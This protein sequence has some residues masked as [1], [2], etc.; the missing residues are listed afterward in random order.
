MTFLE[1][2]ATVIGGIAAA[3]YVASYQCK[4]RKWI[5]F[6]G[7][8][9][10][11]L[12][13]LQYILLGAFSG[14]ALDLIAILAALVAGKKDH[15]TLKKLLVPIIVV[16]HVAILV[17]SIL[18]SQSL[19]DIVVLLAATFC[20]AALWFTKE[21]II[22]AVSFLSSPCWLVYNLSSKAY[23]S[24]VSD[25]FAILSLLIAIWRYDIRKKKA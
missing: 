19:Y 15:P 21:R 8:L 20:V 4:K 3:I 23:F 7:A 9:S 17:T 14:T 2:I 24:A 18:L 22:R 1:I 11:M 25:S 16:I 10:R 5:L 13:I 12:F 6:L